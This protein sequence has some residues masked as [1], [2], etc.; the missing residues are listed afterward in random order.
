MPFYYV[1]DGAEFDV[2]ELPLEAWIEVQRAT[3][4][5]WHECIGRQLLAD[6]T[7][8]KAVLAEC[9]KATG[10]SLP[11]KITVKTLLQIFQHR[12]GENRP[13]GFNEGIPD[14]KATDTDPATT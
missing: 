5:Q 10:T 9:A 7:V 11:A 1:N 3:G 13:E 8:A 12:D 2:E 14:P 4:R 6:V